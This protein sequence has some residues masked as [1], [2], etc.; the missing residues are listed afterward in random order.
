MVGQAMSMVMFGLCKKLQVNG[1]RW[2]DLSLA[3][4]YV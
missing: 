4:C 1:S 2:G 3:A